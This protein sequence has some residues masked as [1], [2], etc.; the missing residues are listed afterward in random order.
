MAEGERHG[1]SGYFVTLD[2]PLH[3]DVTGDSAYVV[4]P[5]TMSFT[6]DGNKVTQ[7]GAVFTVA[8]RQRPDGW[9]LAAWAWTK[10]KQ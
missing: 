8:L 1:A 3:G 6:V 5:A 7:F 10:G 4:V 2:T 9:R